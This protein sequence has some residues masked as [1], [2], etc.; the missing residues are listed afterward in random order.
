MYYGYGIDPTIII[1]IP[2]ILFALFAQAKVKSAFNRYSS[3]PNSLGITGA[4]AARRV[5]DANG[6]QDVRIEAIGGSL[7]DNYDPRDRTLHLSQ[8]VCNVDSVAAVSVAC[9]EC[10]HAIQHQHHYAPLTIRNA[11]VPVVNF[12]SNV[13]WILIMV[14][15]ILLFAGSSMQGLGDT[16]FDIGVICFV[17]VILFHLITLPVELN[18]SHRALQQ[19]KQLQLVLPENYKG[20]R[21]VLTAAAMTYIAALAMAVAN[22]LRI[23]ALR[24][25]R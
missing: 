11:I 23:L 13:S 19:M 25:D 6:L 4:Q 10:G 24:G 7:T 17:V 21:K 8:T 14:G 2:A 22:L 20:S 12:A 1:L 3:V 5:L 15:I 18:A 9:H 16:L